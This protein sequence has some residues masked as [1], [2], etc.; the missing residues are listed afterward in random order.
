MYFLYA[1]PLYKISHKVVLCYFLNLG[2]SNLTDNAGGYDNQISIFGEGPFFSRRNEWLNYHN[3]VISN[4]TAQLRNLDTDSRNSIQNQELSLY[5][6]P[7]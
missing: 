6:V 5:I 1:R 3:F 7:I 2:Y 4:I